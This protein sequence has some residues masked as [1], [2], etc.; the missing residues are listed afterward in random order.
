VSTHVTEKPPR[1][2]PPPLVRTINAVRTGLQRLN[3]RLAPGGINVIELLI[4]AWTAQCIHVAVKLGIPDQLAGGPCP[5]TRS[6]AVS[7]RTPTR[8]TG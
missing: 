2:P 6:P 1:I 7:A 4:G 8:C 3:R 5:P